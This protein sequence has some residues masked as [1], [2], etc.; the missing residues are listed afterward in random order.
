M[1]ITITTL[2]ITIKNPKL[3]MPLCLVSF[4]LSAAVG[5]IMLSVIMLF[6]VCAECC[7]LAHYAE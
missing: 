6:V 3:R 7:N 1:T 5:R 2:S 4:M